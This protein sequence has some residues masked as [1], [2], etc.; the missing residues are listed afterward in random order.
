MHSLRA[1]TEAFSFPLMSPSPAV[2]AGIWWFLGSR[3][4]VHDWWD[5]GLMGRREGSVG[6]P[7]LPPFSPRRNNLHGAK[8][9][10]KV[11]GH[12]F[13]GNSFCAPALIHLLLFDLQYSSG[14]IFMVLYCSVFAWQ[15]LPAS[16]TKR[17]TVHLSYGASQ[18]LAA[19]L[20]LQASE[21]VNSQPSQ[22][23]L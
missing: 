18:D 5:V 4:P 17:V 12:L 1:D 11:P 7:L 13:H 10:P 2:M 15:P 8:A 22:K 3:C 6:C 21:Y 23:H 16:S 14:E 9:D 19:H 20:E